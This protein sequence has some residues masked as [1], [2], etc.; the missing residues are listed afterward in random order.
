MFP[1]FLSSGLFLGWSLGANDAA[2]IFGTAVGSRM[3]RFKTA[4]I[5]CSI[6]VI[7]GAVISGAGASHTLGK[8][9]AVNA[10][11][12]AFMVALS[13]ALTVYLMTLASYPVS[14]SQAIVGAILGWNFFSG[15]L[16]DYHSLLK[17]VTTWVV[18]P[19]LA[20]LFAIVLYKLVAWIIIR[21]KLHML[22]LDAATRYGLILAGVFGA[23]ALGANNIANVMGVFVPVSPFA[24]IT[25][26]GI[27][28][29]SAGQQLFFLGG[30]AIALGVF[31]Y[32]K[33]VMLTV[34]KGIFR[35]SP[36]AA[37]VVVVAHSLVLFLFASERLAHV[38]SS[39]GLPPLPLVPVSSS[40]AI[41]GG[42]IGIGILKKGRGIR[43]PLLGG[44][45]TG[46]VLTPIIAGLVC[47]VSLFFLQ[48]VFEQ[49]TYKPVSFM[50]SPG[51][52]ERISQNSDSAAGRLQS[53]AGKRFASATKFRAAVLEQGDFSD[54]ELDLILNFAEVVFL[55]VKSRVLPELDQEWFSPEQ[56]RALKELEGRVFK[57]SWSLK[58]AL[59]KLTPAW[60]SP[61]TESGTRTRIQNK[62][63]P[64]RS[65]FQIPD[66]SS[67]TVQ[68]Q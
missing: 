8:L 64:L 48:N 61:E 49:Q 56:I 62:L 43:W 7:L 31:T 4:A 6:F 15:S 67:S 27:L 57:H 45:A 37:F 46:W 35:L 36:V 1:F 47:Y 55:Q 11:P 65:R 29:L 21:F 60:R 30:L 28:T 24:D 5:L 63:D 40:Q 19:V 16:T 52:M 14:T 2:N 59:A 39:H 42:V 9:G 3:I 41:V 26:F 32:S 33:R 13:A 20:A 53:L 12:G 10:L 17:I 66:P 22:I 58:Q 23:Y 18:C 68:P 25:I 50:I 44:I 34:G 51:A 54:E 38:L